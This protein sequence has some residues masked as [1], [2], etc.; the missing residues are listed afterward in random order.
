MMLFTSMLH[1]S[2]LS[3]TQKDVTKVLFAFMNRNGFYFYVNYSIEN[4]HLV[5]FVTSFCNAIPND[6]FSI[7]PEQVVNFL[8]SISES[9]AVFEPVCKLFAKNYFYLFVVCTYVDII[10]IPVKNCTI[11]FGITSMCF[12]VLDIDLHNSGASN[13]RYDFQFQSAIIICCR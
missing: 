2:S 7:A 1:L 13:D 11:A 8:T 5:Q 6:Q 3:L 12:T 4:A 10:N 9:T